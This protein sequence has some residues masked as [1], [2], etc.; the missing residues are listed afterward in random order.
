MAL[1]DAESGGAAGRFD[2]ARVSLRASAPFA[3][4]ASLARQ[5]K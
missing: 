1:R 3:L 2:A 4:P 5:W